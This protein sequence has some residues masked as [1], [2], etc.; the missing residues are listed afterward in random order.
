MAVTR[1]GQDRFIT[2]IGTGSDSFTLPGTVLED[3]IVRVAVASDQSFAAS[4][5]V[6]TSGYATLYDGGTQN[7]A[8]QVF[9]K[10]MGSTPDTA[11]LIEQNDN[12][13]ITVNVRVVRG[14]D[15]TTAIDATPTTSSGG[16]GAPDGPSFTSVTNGALHEVIGFTDDDDV[17]GYGGDAEPSGWD[18]YYVSDTEQASTTTGA[19]IQSALKLKATAGAEDP[20]AFTGGD[21]AWEAVHYA[22]R[23]AVGT[24]YSVTA[25]AGT[26]TFTGSSVTLIRGRNLAAEAGAFTFTG[27]AVGLIRARYLTAA[28]GSFTFAGQSVTLTRTR[29]PAPPPGLDDWPAIVPAV[30]GGGQ[31]TPEFMEWLRGL[32]DEVRDLRAASDDY[33]T[34]ITAL[35]P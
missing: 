5:K 7:P 26:F 34:R 19:S 1:E 32:V 8:A 3:D 35:E 23:P 11:V 29:V 31:V 15:T 20:G 12:R 13:I 10:R 14:V 21:D 9:W 33:E 22:W 27:G 25:S 16:T 17:E 4:L 24:A 2:G 30:S 6:L 28:A 18:D